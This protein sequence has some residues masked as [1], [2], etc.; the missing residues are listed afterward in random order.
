[1]TKHFAARPIQAILCSALLLAS[2]QSVEEV[3]T[4]EVCNDM[5]VVTLEQIEEKKET[6]VKMREFMDE[7]QRKGNTS[8]Y[9]AQKKSYVSHRINGIGG[10]IKYIEEQL[11]KNCDTSKF[12]PELM[13]GLAEAKKLLDETEQVPTAG[14]EGMPDIRVSEIKSTFVPY[15]MDA[16]GRCEGPFLDLVFTVT[17]NG[18]SYPRPVDVEEYERRAQRPARDLE[19]FV[20]TGLASFAT[21][22]AKSVDVTIKGGSGGNIPKGGSL[23]IP[24]SI[25]ID[26]DQTKAHIT[27]KVTT[28]AFLKNGNE[29]ITHEIDVDVP[30]WDI[31]T[32]N[33][34]ALVSKDADDGKM[35]F[36]A[37]AT[38]S[39]KGESPT[40]G[41]VQGSFVLKDADTGR[42]VTGWTGKTDGPV[43][44]TAQMFVR[45]PFTGKFPAHLKVDSAIILLC[46]DGT[47][48]NLT[49]GNAKNNTRELQEG[50]GGA[51][52]SAATSQ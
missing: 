32:E 30:V 14:A 41:P 37:I 18:E 43:S 40:P 2:C 42:Y 38:I 3:F 28:H 47:S 24:A 21:G 49:D 17:N 11:L 46:P 20:F 15:R 36:G 26:Y 10:N 50:G 1:M 19:Y 27:G 23:D 44:G 35:Y 5:F 4:P 7:A 22:P 29:G 9:E 45:E 12:G 8:D 16:M 39:N 48:G 33:H 25:K 51:A 6:M 52:T 13:N 34:Q 31:Y